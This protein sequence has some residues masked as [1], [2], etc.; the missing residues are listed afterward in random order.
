MRRA[1][2]SHNK[3]GMGAAFWTER[4]KT[5]E[6]R[7]SA[8]DESPPAWRALVNEYG[9]EPVVELAKSGM[10]DAKRAQ[11]YLDRSRKQY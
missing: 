9:L 5:A 1:I 4:K 8:I 6:E 11:W 2:I 3:P 10:T 7:M